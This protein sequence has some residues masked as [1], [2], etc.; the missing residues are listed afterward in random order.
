LSTQVPLPPRYRT[1][2]SHG[3]FHVFFSNPIVGQITKVLSLHLHSYFNLSVCT[4]CLCIF[5]YSW[6]KLSA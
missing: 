4:V 3:L 5:I 2:E 1:G 6:P